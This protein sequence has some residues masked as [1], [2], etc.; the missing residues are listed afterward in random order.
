MS[1]NF[2]PSKLKLAVRSGEFVVVRVGGFE[3]L[4]KVNGL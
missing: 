3:W 2:K 4:S 1:V